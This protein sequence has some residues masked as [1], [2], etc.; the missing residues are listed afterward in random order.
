[1]VT[2]LHK[3]TWF[4]LCLSLLLASC[5]PTQFTQAPSD[6]PPAP[7]A[8]AFP[9]FTSTNTP[10]NTLTPTARP[11]TETPD[12]SPYYAT[13]TAIVEAVVNSGQPELF[14]SYSSPDQ[15]WRIDILIYSCVQIQAGADRYAYEQLML[16]ETD[17]ETGRV[18]ESQ[19][20][21]CG[22]MGAYGLEGLF[23]SA[24]SHYFYYTDAREGVPDGG[25]WYWRPRVFLLDPSTNQTELIGSGPISPDTKKMALWQG[26]EIVVWDTDSGEIGRLEIVIPQAANGPIVWS[27]DSQSLVYLL[28]DSD[29]APTGNSYLVRLD[30]E[31]LSQS[32]I[33]DSEE[34]R[35]VDAVWKELNWLELRDVENKLWRYDFSDQT[36]SLLED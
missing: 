7:T 22:G 10:A 36:L 27:P 4:G 3:I 26:K 24:N 32:L 18:I 8:S 21:S 28:N 14:A 16:V 13:Q 12:Y 31:R 25:C 30:I 2:S 23:W 17:T 15:K 9:G 1:M 11:P 29:C 5:R 35:F 19:L 20:Q 33:L 34:P 6:T